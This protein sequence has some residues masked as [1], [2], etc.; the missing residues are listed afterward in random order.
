MTVRDY[1]E[2]LLKLLG[3]KM[4]NEYSSLKKELQNKFDENKF[5]RVYEIDLIIKKKIEEII[6][7]M[8]KEL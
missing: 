6:E 4:Y 8:E 7:K 5:K 2:F 3:E 1:E